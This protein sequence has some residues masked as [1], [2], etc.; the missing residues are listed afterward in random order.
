MKRKRTRRER[1]EEEYERAKGQIHRQ[2]RK[3]AR[4]AR[5]EP[6]VDRGDLMGL[7]HVA[8]VE[9]FL[10]YNRRK[11]TFSRW[12]SVRLHR[13]LAAELRDRVRRRGYARTTTGD[14]G[15]VPAREDAAMSEDAHALASVALIAAGQGLSPGKCRRAAR[16]VLLTMG[17][18]GARVERAA[19]EIRGY[20]TGG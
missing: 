19:S 5:H 17:W 20:L 12:L 8:F 10:T 3:F 1:M 9:A 6:G 2:V 15:W 14:M 16:L 13:A 18:D 11:A 4:F 7:A